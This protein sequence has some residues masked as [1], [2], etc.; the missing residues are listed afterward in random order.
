MPTNEDKKQK[1]KDKHKRIRKSY[2]KMAAG[3][4]KKTHKD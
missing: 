2:L 1:I 3:Q 4:V